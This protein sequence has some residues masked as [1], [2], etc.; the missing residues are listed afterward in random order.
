MTIA[1]SIKAKSQRSKNINTA[2]VAIAAK[3]LNTPTAPVA[4]TSPNASTSL[5]RRVINLPT[6]VRSK[7][8]VDKEVTWRN[9]S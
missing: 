1:T 3:S 4:N 7:K 9:K 5:V 8:L 6:G 2:I